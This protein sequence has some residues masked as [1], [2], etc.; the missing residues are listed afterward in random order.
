M[1]Q[2]VSTSV[3]LAEAGDFG[4]LN[5]VWARYWP[6][7]PPARTTVVAKLPVTGARIQ[8]SAIAA[9]SGTGRAAVLPKGWASP[10][11]PLS[12]AMR[13]GDTLFLS[14][15]SRDAAPTTAS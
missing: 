4:A 10:A 1:D 7:S 13:T 5:A 8:V 6:A 14:G 15:S 11:G 12:Y 3:Y 2:V 9:A